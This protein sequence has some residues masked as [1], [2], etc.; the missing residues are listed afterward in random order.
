MTERQRERQRDKD[1][2]TETEKCQITA[3]PGQ[4]QVDEE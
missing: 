1:R 2:E 3:A 4:C